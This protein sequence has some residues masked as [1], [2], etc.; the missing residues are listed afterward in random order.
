MPSGPA[1]VNASP[2]IFLGKAKRLDLL[3]VLKRSLV[4]PATVIEEIATKGADDEVLRSVRESGFLGIVPD[5]PISPQIAAWRLGAGESAVLSRASQH[6]DSL[7][8]LDDREGR[9]CADELGIRSVGT[10]GIVV[11]AK[12]E[13]AI[14]LAGP[15]IQ[16]LISCGLYVSSQVL[17]AALALAGERQDS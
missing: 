4:V 5:V 7:V 2:L 14:P 17:D 16:E 9:R 6:Q 1:V 13:G 15:V 3:R 11:L 8:V 12:E 10:L